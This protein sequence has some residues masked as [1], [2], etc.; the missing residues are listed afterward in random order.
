MQIACATEATVW[1][2]MTHGVLPYANAFTKAEA[3]RALFDR[4]AIREV[5]AGGARGD[6]GRYF[7]ALTEP[8][9]LGG[10]RLLAE[11]PLPSGMRYV[12]QP[13]A[14]VPPLVLAYGLYAERARTAPKARSMSIDALT[15]PG[16]MGRALHL[17]LDLDNLAAR[18]RRLKARDILDFTQTADLRDVGFLRP[19]ADPL[20]FLELY[21]DEA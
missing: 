7:R 4:P 1:Y 20:R 8:V 15:A 12:R 19:D 13:S 16:S 2:E 10:L 14:H 3:E 6:L 17:H 21:Y 18:V 11:L 9:A 5:G